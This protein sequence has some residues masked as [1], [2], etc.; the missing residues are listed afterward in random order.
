MSPYLVCGVESDVQP[1]TGG[2]GNLQR[3]PDCLL[4]SPGLESRLCADL[5]H[6]LSQPLHQVSHISGHSVHQIVSFTTATAL[7]TSNRNIVSD[8]CTYEDILQAVLS[9][10]SLL[11][12]L[13]ILHCF[14]VITLSKWGQ[15]R[16]R[17]SVFKTE[18]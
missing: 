12:N 15:A 1:L 11:S 4:P 9:L 5:H 2:Q 8:P 7:N 13:V 14:Y 6:P 16:S 17:S 3:L 10:S 18:S